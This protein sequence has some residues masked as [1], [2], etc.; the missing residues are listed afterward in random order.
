MNLAKAAARINREHYL[1]CTAVQKGLGHAMK[2][3]DVL[4]GVKGRLEHG[5]WLP[6]LT[7]NCP[8]MGIRHAQNYMRLA[9]KRG[10]IEAK[11]ATDAYL[12]IRAALSYL[13]EDK[14]EEEVED[15][16]EAN[17]LLDEM[18]DDAFAALMDEEEQALG[19][20]PEVMEYTRE[21]LRQQGV[22]G[23]VRSRAKFLAAGEL[24]V[25]LLIDQA[26][27]AARRTHLEVAA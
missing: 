23:L 25:L 20:E 22:K 8:E 7:E 4:R 16:D 26:L 10:E 13:A 6:W 27:E 19:D 2:A 12:T 9:R 5:Q 15:E 24:K 1:A 18:T 14:A 21:E 11:Y 3:G 17:R